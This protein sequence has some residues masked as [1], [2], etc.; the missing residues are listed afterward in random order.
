MRHRGTLGSLSYRG[1]WTTATIS[2]FLRIS[3]I[4]RDFG[5]TN[6]LPEFDLRK[7]GYSNGPIIFM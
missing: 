4:V 7:L 2:P 3:N 6:Y 1:D 5:K